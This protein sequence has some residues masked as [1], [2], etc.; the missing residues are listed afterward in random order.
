MNKLSILLTFTIQSL[1]SASH[2]TATTERTVNYIKGCKIYS[3]DLLGHDNKNNLCRSC[4]KGYFIT[5]DFNC[6]KCPFGC[7]DCT[8]DKSCISCYPS[9]FL[10]AQNTCEKCPA[11]CKSC[12]SNS[13]CNT[14][15]EGHYLDDK[16]QCQI[17]LENCA[18]CKDSSKC[19]ECHK[20][21][22]LS[23][24]KESCVTVAKNSLR[25]TLYMT[26]MAAIGLNGFWCFACLRC[27]IC[28]KR[29]KR[30]YKDSEKDEHFHR[31]DESSVFN[32]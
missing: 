18:F 25:F 7:L 29:M 27:F 17:C 31:F 24:D 30:V 13:K 5:P 19:I 26:A 1:A 28:R 23:K 2:L 22:P 21:Y 10:N 15:M 8:H 20:G 3:D 4:Y 9:H 14:C 11:D 16:N 6:G 12:S 32:L